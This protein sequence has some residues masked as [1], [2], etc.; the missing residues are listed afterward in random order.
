MA[1][2]NAQVPL[3][4]VTLSAARAEI[5]DFEGATAAGMQAVSVFQRSGDSKMAAGVE[6]DLLPAV[7]AHQAIRDN[8]SLRQ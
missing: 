2:T 7:R 5:G 3:F 8:P 4:L 6:S 1:A